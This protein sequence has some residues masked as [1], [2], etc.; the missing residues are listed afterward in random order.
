[1][2]THHYVKVVISLNVGVGDY[3]SGGLGWD[4]V[5]ENFREWP[6]NCKIGK[7]FLSQKKP[8][9]HQ[10]ESLKVNNNH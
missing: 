2:L 9:T 6:K 3:D 8:A 10:Q 1:M 4:Y 5:E 7:T